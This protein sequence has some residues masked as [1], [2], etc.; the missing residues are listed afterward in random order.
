MNVSEHCRRGVISIA[1]GADIVAA[2]RLMRDQHVGFLSVYRQGD[3]VHRPVGVLTDRDIVLQVT[4]A[5]RDPRATKV[6]DVMTRQPLIANESDELRDILQVMRLAGIRRVPIVD[7]HGAPVGIIAIDDAIELI[8]GLL[9]DISGSI[10]SER[11][12]EWR[13]HA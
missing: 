10:G 9:C 5:G 8:T 4:A 1:D 13:A 6:H 3:E 11:H 2:S 12:R 7:A